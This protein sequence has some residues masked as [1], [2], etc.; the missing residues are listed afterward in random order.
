M[1]EPGPSISPRIPPFC[2][3]IDEGHIAFVTSEIEA[4]L[5]SGHHLTMELMAV[6]WRR[7]SRRARVV[8]HAYRRVQPARARS[9]SSCARSTSPAGQS[10]FRRTRSERR[11][12]PCFGRAGPPVF[13]DAAEGLSISVEAVERRLSANVRAVMTVHIGGAISP[14]TAELA[15]L[16]SAW[17]IPLV[18]DAATP[19]APLMTGWRR[20]AGASPRRSPC[21]ARRSSRA[22][23][24]G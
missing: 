17:G 11:R 4:L 6:R 2:Y 20:A 3:R 5:R 24:A 18:E 7:R 1:L 14:G 21:S 8:R 9:K 22:A 12:S 16:C 23:R 13:A 15:E 19:P 10:S